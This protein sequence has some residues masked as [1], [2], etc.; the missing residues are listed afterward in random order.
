MLWRRSCLASGSLLPADTS[1]TPA[2][3][4][5]TPSTVEA[6]GRKNPL[7]LGIQQSARRRLV[8]GSLAQSTERKV[9]ADQM[10]WG[11]TLPPEG[12]TILPSQVGQAIER[13]RFLSP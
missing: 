2:R 4:C 6:S 11:L 8:Q 13:K 3:D 7:L 9:N 1:Q 10:S 12:Q 5:P